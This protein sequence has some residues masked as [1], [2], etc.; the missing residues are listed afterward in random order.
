[1][2]RLLVEIQAGKLLYFWWK[3]GVFL[4]DLWCRMVVG[5]E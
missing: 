1:M 3:K 5:A 4:C 2:T